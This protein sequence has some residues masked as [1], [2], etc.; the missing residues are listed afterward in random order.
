MFYII[1]ICKIEHESFLVKTALCS[2][3]YCTSFS[4]NHSISFSCLQMWVGC[5]FTMN[6]NGQRY[7]IVGYCGLLTC[8][9]TPNLMVAEC[10]HRHLNP[11]VL[12]RL[13]CAGFYSKY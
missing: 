7:E 12:D 1:G 8:P 6:A 3:I 5:F 4:R 13:L 10:W 2:Q 11:N 9:V